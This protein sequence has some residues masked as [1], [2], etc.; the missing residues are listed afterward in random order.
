MSKAAAAVVELDLLGLHP[1]PPPPPPVRPPL[2]AG[3]APSEC[4]IARMDPAV[5]KSVIASGSP[6][7]NAAATA[8]SGARVEAGDDTATSP[9]TIF[10]NGTVGVF[11]LTHD[12]AK[13]ILR[14]AAEASNGG[15]SEASEEKMV[16]GD[17]ECLNGGELPIARRKSL[18]RF[19]E[20]RKERGGRGRGGGAGAR[21]V[22]PR[23]ACAGRAGA[24]RG[25]LSGRAGSGRRGRAGSRRRGDPVRGPS[26]F[27]LWVHSS[28]SLF[29]TFLFFCLF[30]FPNTRRSVSASTSAA[31]PLD[32][33]LAAE[34][35]AECVDAVRLGALVRVRG[36]VGVYRGAVQITIAD[37]VVEKDPNS[38]VLHWLDCIRLAR[39]YYDVV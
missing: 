11:E 19:L 2:S 33:V 36:C 32:V 29:F 17:N 25:A 27:P 3:T 15:I 6:G 18:Q 14:M 16:S 21:V 26:S 12:K 39:D 34:A 1:R 7:S 35:A 13:N 8:I 23:G 38:E 37:V 31:P 9:L 20:R 4:A 10:Y 24:E 22:A 28:V 30:S 5:V